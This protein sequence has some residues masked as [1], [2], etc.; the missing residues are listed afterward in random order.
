[1]KNSILNNENINKTTHNLTQREIE[2]LALVALGLSNNKIAE[3]LFV[4]TSTVKKT[5]ENIFRKLNA[6][7]RANAVALAIFY[8]FLNAQIIYDVKNNLRNF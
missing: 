1:M 7:D 4:T 5:L 2:Y 8:D 6:H 3:K